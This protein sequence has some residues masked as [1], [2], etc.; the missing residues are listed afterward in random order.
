MKPVHF[1][2]LGLLFA[3]GWEWWVPNIPGDFAKLSLMAYIR[4]LAPHPQPLSQMRD[5]ERLF[6]IG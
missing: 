5:L 2:L 6:S 4:V 3:F 1:L